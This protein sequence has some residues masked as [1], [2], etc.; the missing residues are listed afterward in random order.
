MGADYT[1]DI[2]DSNLNPSKGAYTGQKKLKFWCQKVLP[3]VYDDS[4]SYYETICRVVQK[5]NELAAK[6]NEVDDL[7]NNLDQHLTIEVTRILHEWYEDGTLEEIIG[8]AL[9]NI[10]GD[11][12]DLSDDVGDINDS[13]STINDSI[14]S[15]TAGVA[16]A[17]GIADDARLATMKHTMSGRKCFLIGNSYA[18]GTGSDQGHGWTYYFQALTGCEGTICN[19]N[20]GDFVSPGNS[21]ADYPNKT[22]IECL[23]TIFGTMPEVDR[24]E[25]EYVIVGGGYNDRDYTG[26]A[27]AVTAFVNRCRQL[28]PNAKVWVIPLFTGRRLNHVKEYNFGVDWAAGAAAAGAATNTN[29]F[30]WFF[31]RRDLWYETEINVHLNDAGYQVCARYMAALIDGWDGMTQTQDGP[32]ATLEAGITTSG[33]RCFR[34]GDRVSIGGMLKLPDDQPVSDRVYLAVLNDDV[35]P[36][37]IKFFPVY[38]YI[39]GSGG[40]LCTLATAAINAE[41]GKLSLEPTNADVQSGSRIYFSI[42]YTIII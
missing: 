38:C 3:L 36:S 29:T 23:E 9:D 40:S 30:N 8:T 5:L 7:I 24:M 14:T 37:T 2:P 4:L 28:L 18:A 19:Q 31:G 26:V 20:G 35:R 11:V 17:A 41:S 39:A 13:I 16:A 33:F 42:D 12:S 15:L 22:Y 27:A 21:N 10:A 34:K 32:N 1:P 6:Y 25:Y